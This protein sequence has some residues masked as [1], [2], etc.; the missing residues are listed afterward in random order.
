MTLIINPQFLIW[1]PTGHIESPEIFCIAH[2]VSQNKNSSLDW[3]CPIQL[4]TDPAPHIV[5]TCPPSLIFMHCPALRAVGVV[6]PSSPAQ[7]RP[8]SSSLSGLFA[9]FLFLWCPELPPPQH[10]MQM[11]RP[12]CL[13]L[14]C[15]VLPSHLSEPVCP[16][17]LTLKVTASGTHPRYMLSWYPVLSQ[18]T[19]HTCSSCVMSILKCMSVTFS[20]F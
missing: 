20:S 10:A 17:G 9:F 2:S 14:R 1:Q 15:L 18:S 4:A 13:S 6:P 19:Y 5:L 11:A 8:L 7:L 16:S 3:P 12:P